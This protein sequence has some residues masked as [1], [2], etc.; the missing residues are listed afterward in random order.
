MLNSENVTERSLEL[1][2]VPIV[3]RGATLKEALDKMTDL[4]LGIA[5][6][7]DSEQKLL[8]VLTDGD[9]RR[10]LLTRQSPLPALLVTPAIEFGT[11]NPKYIEANSSVEEAKR[12]MS[13][14]EI[15]D[16]PILTADKKLL[17]LVHRH[18]LN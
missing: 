13:N 9:L 4:R 18:N 15:W 5:L 16:L 14:L 3:S 7:V 10:L 2:K 8:G 11:R 1:S 12:L 17:G 6:I